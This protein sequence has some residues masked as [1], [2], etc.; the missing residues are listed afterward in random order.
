[1][2]Q[3]DDERDDGS[4]VLGEGLLAVPSTERTSGRWGTVYLTDL[5]DRP[6]HLRR[7]GT[8]ETAAL[9]AAPLSDNDR[10]SLP[11]K[12][13]LLG[14]GALF[15]ERATTTFGTSHAVGVAPSNGRRT[16]WLH[17]STVTRLEGRRVRLEA[18]PACPL[19]RHRTCGVAEVGELQ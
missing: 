19:D 1:M 17:E 10:I 18:H 8:G 9:T 7:I 13:E 11:V 4:V 12:R 3:F 16:G 14:A 6:I 2:D 5:D 15:S